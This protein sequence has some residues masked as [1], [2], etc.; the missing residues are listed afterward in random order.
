MQPILDLCPPSQSSLVMFQGNHFVCLG[1]VSYDSITTFV[2]LVLEQDHGNPVEWP[3]PL[4]N[5]FVSAA[6]L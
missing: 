6:S 4:D 3:I 1:I 2:C 5:G